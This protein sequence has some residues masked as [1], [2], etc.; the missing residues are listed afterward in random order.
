MLIKTTFDMTGAALKLAR[1]LNDDRY[2]AQPKIAVNIPSVWFP[3]SHRDSAESMLRKARGAILISGDLRNVADGGIGNQIFLLWLA[4]LPTEAMSS[5]LVDTLGSQWDAALEAARFA[6]ID[7]EPTLL[8]IK[9]R[10][11]FLGLF[12]QSVMGWFEGGSSPYWGGY[13]A[14]LQYMWR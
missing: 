8:E 13:P 2:I 1:W 9:A 10:G 6:K 14:M 7:G 11:S 4:E 3:K 5:D 12:S